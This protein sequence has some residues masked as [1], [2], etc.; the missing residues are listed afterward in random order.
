ML[1]KYQNSFIKF[2]I[3]NYGGSYSIVD[4]LLV[5]QVDTDLF[6][7]NLTDKERFGSYTLYHK[8]NNRLDGKVCFH[9]QCKTRNLDF[10]LFVSF[11]HKF[12]K[13]LGI[14]FEKEDFMRFKQDCIKYS[15][16]F[17]N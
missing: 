2:C 3:D 6:K 4:N 16:D 5:M 8:S 9:V 13:N 14:K 17:N 1:N 12:N 11:V 15:N 7:V 10:A